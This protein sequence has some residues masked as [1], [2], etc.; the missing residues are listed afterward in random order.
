MVVVVSFVFVYVCCRF[1]LLLLLFWCEAIA[2]IY[3]PPNFRSLRCISNALSSVCVLQCW[4]L[5][6]SIFFLFLNRSDCGSFLNYRSDHRIYWGGVW[7][8]CSKVCPSTACSSS[9]LQRYKACIGEIMLMHWTVE[10][11]IVLDPGK[12]ECRNKAFE[13]WCGCQTKRKQETLYPMWNAK[14]LFTSFYLRSNSDNT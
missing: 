6:F 7:H 13:E 4:E 14:H 1:L 2:L 3:C 9:H 11:C 8:L 10:D 5:T 12:Q